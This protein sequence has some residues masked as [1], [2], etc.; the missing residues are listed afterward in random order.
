MIEFVRTATGLSFP[1]FEEDSRLAILVDEIARAL[2]TRAR[3]PIGSPLERLIGYEGYPDGFALWW[4]G[5]TCELGCAASGEVDLDVIA[6]RLSNSDR[7]LP[8]QNLAR[9]T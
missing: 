3:K 2:G 6:E 4:D 7:F 8:L 9:P 5:C 1:H